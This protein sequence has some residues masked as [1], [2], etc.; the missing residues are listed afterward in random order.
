[1]WLAQGSFYSCRIACPE[2]DLG[3]SYCSGGDWLSAYAGTRIDPQYLMG[4]PDIS[5]R[6]LNKTWCLANSDRTK[7]GV[8]FHFIGKLEDGDLGRDPLCPNPL[9]CVV[10][11]TYHWKGRGGGNVTFNATALIYHEL[12]PL[13]DGRPVVYHEWVNKVFTLVHCCCL[14]CSMLVIRFPFR[15]R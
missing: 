7:T 10:S 3:A 13:V 6:D 1:M 5:L 12:L 9:D 15:R 8:G 2:A 4:G 14:V 11:S